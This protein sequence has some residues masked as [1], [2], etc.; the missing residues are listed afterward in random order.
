[1]F[2]TEL[3]QQVDV[4]EVLLATEAVSQVFARVD[5]GTH[6]TATGTQKAEVA[7]APFGGRPLP[8]QGG[9]H[10]RRARLARRR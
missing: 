4:V 7:F 1:M 9:D 6:F 5:G 3:D 10:D 8:P 2:V